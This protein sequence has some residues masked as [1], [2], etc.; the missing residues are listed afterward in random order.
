MG[1]ERTV[2]F[3]RHCCG[4]LRDMGRALG[5]HWESRKSRDRLLVKSRK[6]GWVWCT[7][8]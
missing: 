3:Q 1:K 4:G 2:G 5:Q 8:L 6:P 7:C